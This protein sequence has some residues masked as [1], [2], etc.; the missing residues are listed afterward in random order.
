VCYDVEPDVT[1]AVVDQSGDSDAALIAAWRAGQESAAAELVRRHT[2]GLA[3]FLAAAG[4]KEDLDDLVQETFFR[5]F[6]SIERFRGTSAFR[7]WLMAIGSNALKDLRRRRRVIVLPIEEG[8]IEDRSSDPH[9]ETIERDLLDRLQMQVASLPPMQRNVFLMRAQQ[10]AAYEEIAAALHTSV[11]AARVHY[12]QAV[13]RLKA[14]L[15]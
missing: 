14:L 13:K 3:R 5:A 1:A 15:E 7:T 8:E 12:H 2:D 4:A 10:G 11:G 9:A 6:R